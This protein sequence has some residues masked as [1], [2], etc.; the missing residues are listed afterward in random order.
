MRNSQRGYDSLFL[1]KVEAA[2]QS[3]EVMLLAN[4]CIDK[5]VPM[6]EVALLC[7]VTRATVYNWFTGRTAP[8]PRH[9]TQM[10]KIILRLIKRK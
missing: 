8:H 9:R 3:A 2:D 5:G 1:Q 10:S 4:V 6:A 7:G